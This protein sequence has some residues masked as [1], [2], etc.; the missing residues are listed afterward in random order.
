MSLNGPTLNDIF[1]F[2]NIRSPN[3][4]ILGQTMIPHMYTYDDKCALLELKYNIF[5]KMVAQVAPATRQFTV[6]EEEFMILK[7]LIDS[8]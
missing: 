5:P 6:T 1:Q 2:D 4:V 7:M 3:H 8:K